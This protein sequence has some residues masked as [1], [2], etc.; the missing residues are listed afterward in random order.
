[1]EDNSYLLDLAELKIN[2]SKL[3]NLLKRRYLTED[4]REFYIICKLVSEIINAK[5]EE[6]VK[7]IYNNYN[8]YLFYFTGMLFENKIKFRKSKFIQLSENYFMNL[9]LKNK[10]TEEITTK[11]KIVTFLYLDPDIEDLQVRMLMSLRFCKDI[12]NLILSY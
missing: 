4:Y 8:L 12:L 5:D 1:M 11:F 9:F 10:L 3:F 6:K 7:Q 2:N